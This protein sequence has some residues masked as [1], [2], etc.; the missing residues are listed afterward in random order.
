MQFIVT[1][2]TKMNQNNYC[3]AAWSI[4]QQKVV[5]R[6][7][8][9]NHWS[10]QLIDQ[11]Q[12]RPGVILTLEPTGVQHPGSY[13]H[14]T[15]DTRISTNIRYVGQAN[16]GWPNEIPVHSSL[17]NAFSHQVQDN[18]Q[19]W[20]NALK[21]VYVHQGTQVPS[22]IG[23]TITPG[24]LTLITD[25]YNNQPKLRA[26]LTDTVDTYDLTVSCKQLR[27]IWSSESL[28]AANNYIPTDRELHVRIGLARA[29]GGSPNCALMLNGVL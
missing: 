9:G 12:I 1:E 10:S 25:T 16:A 26:Q 14:T 17:Q 23:L 8:N 6:L 28:D 27:D 20:N 29:F 15:E 22:L 21:P 7:P 5:R 2:V 19:R 18:G 3:V 4:A 11:H 13:P 24:N